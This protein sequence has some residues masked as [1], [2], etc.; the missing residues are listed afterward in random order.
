M[1][2]LLGRCRAGRIAWAVG[3]VAILALCAGPAAASNPTPGS[4]PVEAQATCLNGSPAEM[5]GSTL[6]VVEPVRERA[7]RSTAPHLPDVAGDGLVDRPAV[8]TGANFWPPEQNG[9]FG[10]KDRWGD[11]YGSEQIPC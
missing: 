2:C 10:V 9:T 3:L 4:K 11:C 6:V 7:V 8:A 1:S 5:A